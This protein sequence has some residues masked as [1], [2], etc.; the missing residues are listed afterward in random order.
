MRVFLPSMRS[1]C[2]R[3]SINITPYVFGIGLPRLV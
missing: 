2:P 3:L 1:F